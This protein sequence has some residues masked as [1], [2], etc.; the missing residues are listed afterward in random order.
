SSKDI[1][2]F[3]SHFPDLQPI[4]KR[5][6]SQYSEVLTSILT[7]IIAFFPFSQC[8]PSLKSNLC[9]QSYFFKNFLAY[10]VT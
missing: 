7:A 5:R 6:T 4:L 9:G 10:K 2:N 8:S 3:L 1:A